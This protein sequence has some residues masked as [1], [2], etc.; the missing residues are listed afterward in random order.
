[1]AESNTDAREALRSLLDGIQSTFKKYG[2]SARKRAWE[3]LQCCKG[4]DAI[5][6]LLNNPNYQLQGVE[7]MLR[8]K[9]WFY[10]QEDQVPID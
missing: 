7:G 10:Q 2:R 6:N 1:M 3:S 8:F 9:E 4:K 5:K